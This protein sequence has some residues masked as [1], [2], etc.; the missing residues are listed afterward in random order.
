MGPAP[1]LLAGGAD[2]GGMAYY[3]GELKAELNG[4]PPEVIQAT[5]RAFQDLI[6]TKVAARASAT[7]GQAE[8]KSATGKEIRVT[9]NQKT[10]RVSAIGIRVGLMGDEDLSR[11]LLDK[12]RAYL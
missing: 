12:I 5:K 8:A 7:D 11:T 4:T 10:P 1:L 2:A 9:V 6:W 3:K